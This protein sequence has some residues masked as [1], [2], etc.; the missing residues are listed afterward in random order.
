MDFLRKYAIL[1]II[2]ALIIGFAIG[3]NS[4]K[5]GIKRLMG[6]I[7]ARKNACFSDSQGECYVK[8]GNQ[9]EYVDC[10]ACGR[11]TS[12]VK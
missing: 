6:A 9:K 12:S 1:F 10:G 7:M 8:V 11:I 4:E 3:Y 5:I 2:L